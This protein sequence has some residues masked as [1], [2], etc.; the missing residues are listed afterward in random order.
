MT[1]HDVLAPSA[2]SDVELQRL[3]STF[4]DEFRR[5]TDGQRQAMI[6]EGPQRPG[7]QEGLVAAVVSALCREVGMEAPVWVREIY[8]P[9]PYFAFPARGFALRLLL[10]LESPPPFRARNV[11]VPENYLARA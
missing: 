3:V 1:V 5:G 6:A 10:M 8:S 9:E 2:C 7:K 4:V 11:F